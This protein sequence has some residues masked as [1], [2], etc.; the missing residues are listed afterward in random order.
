[1]EPRHRALEALNDLKRQ[2]HAGHLVASSGTFTDVL[3]RWLEVESARWK[4]TTCRRNRDITLARRSWTIC[5]PAC[6]T[7]G[8]VK[9]LSAGC[10]PSWRPP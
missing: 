1:M 6:E 3:W 10:M 5:M 8:A 9:P 7:P 2:V 4:A